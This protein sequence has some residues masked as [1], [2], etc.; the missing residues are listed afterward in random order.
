MAEFGVHSWC[1]GENG[2]EAFEIPTASPEH[3]LM[4][5]YFE[6]M[7]GTAIGEGFY[8]FTINSA[9]FNEIYVMNSGDIAKYRLATE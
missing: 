1:C 7:L 6:E 5:N 4:I 3:K 2:E 8:F 9:P